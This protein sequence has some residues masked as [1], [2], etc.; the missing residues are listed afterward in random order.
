MKAH[1]VSL[2]TAHPKAVVIIIAAVVVMVVLARL[3]RGG[4]SAPEPAEYGSGG[5][6]FL[7]ALV[8]AL[9]GAAVWLYAH[10]R[11]SVRTVVRVVKV[12]AAPPPAVSHVT[13]AA[14]AAHPVLTGTEIV[15][16]T[17]FAFLALLVMALNRRS[18]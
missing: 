6:G 13:S 17:G 14:Q 5:S 3:T 2:V 15:V 1:M 12:H 10:G 16:I 8:L 9:S 7:T 4:R 11:Q 18:G